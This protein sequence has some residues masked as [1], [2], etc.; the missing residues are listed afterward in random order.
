MPIARGP[1]EVTRGSTE[2][3]NRSNPVH[4][5][6]RVRKEELDSAEDSQLSLVAHGH[7]QQRCQTFWR[8]F[9]TWF[10]TQVFVW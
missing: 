4:Q 5:C 1:K 10:T 3:R 7:E 2:T 8:R 9:F 6:G